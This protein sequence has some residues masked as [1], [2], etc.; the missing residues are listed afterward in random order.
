MNKEIRNSITPQAGTI[1]ETENQSNQQTSRTNSRANSSSR[2]SQHRIDAPTCRMEMS[3]LT[4]H[5]PKSDSSFSY[6]HRPTKNR[7]SVRQPPRPTIWPYQGESIRPI[8]RG[9]TSWCPDKNCGPCCHGAYNC[10]ACRQ[11]CKNPHTTCPE[12]GSLRH[13]ALLKYRV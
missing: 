3:C 4:R 1:E 11:N 13:D 6:S 7:V 8:R 5:R 9:A 2:A 10:G 12:V